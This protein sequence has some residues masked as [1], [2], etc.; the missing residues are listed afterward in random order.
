MF[1][2]GLGNYDLSVFE[3]LEIGPKIGEVYVIICLLINSIIMIN[4]II[5]IL[6]DTFSKLSTQSLGLYYDG[7]IAKIPIYED[8]SLYGGLIVGVPPFNMLA[9]PMIPF[10]LMVKDEEKLLYYNDLFTKFMFAPVALIS[11]F[12]FLGLSLLYLPFACFSA[13]IKKIKLICKQRKKA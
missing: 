8:D 6:A 7:L 1:G 11:A 9:L 4:F 3:T 13:I 5:A 10:Y 12:M 2:T